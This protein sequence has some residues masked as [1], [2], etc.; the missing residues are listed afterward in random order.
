MTIISNGLSYSFFW[1]GVTTF[2]LTT[3]AL[4]CMLSVLWNYWKSSAP[5]LRQ[6]TEYLRLLG[7]AEPD[8]WDAEEGLAVM[9][10]GV[11]ATHGAIQH[12]QRG[13][14]SEIDSGDP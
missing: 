5:L 13:A 1:W 12:G 2:C 9:D 10:Y 11:E 4:I 7:E 3:T 14:C 6:A 8:C